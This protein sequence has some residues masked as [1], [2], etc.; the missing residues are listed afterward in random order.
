MHGTDWNGIIGLGGLFDPIISE[1]GGGDRG[2]AVNMM[3]DFPVGV[4]MIF[5]TVFCAT[6]A[7]IR[8]T[9]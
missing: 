1:N 2:T 4:F 6:A 5:H 8:I 3:N 7:T 9:R